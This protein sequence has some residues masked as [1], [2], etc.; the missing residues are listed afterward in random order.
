MPLVQ[1]PVD[2]H[3]QY[4][5]FDEEILSRVNTTASATG[6]DNLGNNSG[7]RP[8]WRQTASAALPAAGDDHAAD[9]FDAR[10]Y[11]IR[12]QVPIAASGGSIADVLV[13]Q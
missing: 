11:R 10:C 1:G 5:R 6:I 13:R 3:Q 7:S 9:F 2:P 4:R 12:D 8:V